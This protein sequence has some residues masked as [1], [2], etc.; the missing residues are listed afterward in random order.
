M[1]GSQPFR[2]LQPHEAVIS[3][4]VLGGPLLASPGYFVTILEAGT[5]H[6]GGSGRKLVPHW[7]V[8]SNPP[9]P[10]FPEPPIAVY[11]AWWHC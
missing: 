11:L 3:H 6:L 9:A 1:A 2:S 4:G 5:L 8:E 7:L 10:D